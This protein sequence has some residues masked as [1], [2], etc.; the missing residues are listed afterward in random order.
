M[1]CPE[2][3]ALLEPYARRELPENQQRLLKD[4]LAAC[5][6]CR[7]AVRYLR[8]SDDAIRVALLAGTA[9][10]SQEEDERSR[11]LLRVM[12][13]LGVVGALL[14]GA[15]YMFLRLMAMRANG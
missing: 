13:W 10:Q 8:M 6:D 12:V 4:H 9:R 1:P 11:R 15:L 3:K 5:D 2:Y 7:A 14:V